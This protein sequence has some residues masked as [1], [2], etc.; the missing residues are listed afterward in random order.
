MKKT[1]RKSDQNIAAPL[2]LLLLVSE[3][4]AAVDEV[5]MQH[6]AIAELASLNENLNCKLTGGDNDDYKRLGTDARSTPS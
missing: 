5:G 4:T 3:G 2:K 6:G 1:A